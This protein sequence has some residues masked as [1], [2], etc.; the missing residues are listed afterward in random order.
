MSDEQLSIHPF[1]HLYE[2]QINLTDDVSLFQTSFSTC[3]IDGNCWNA[4]TLC[5]I[6]KEAAIFYLKFKTFILH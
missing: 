3:A 1:R 6:G 5:R 4:K 2:L